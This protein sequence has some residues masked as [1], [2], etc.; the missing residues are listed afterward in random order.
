ML[1]FESLVLTHLWQSSLTIAVVGLAVT[2]FARRRPHLAYALWTLALLKCLTPP[3]VSSPVSP[4]SWS[5][6]AA[7]PSAIGMPAST[8]VNYH[9]APA[10]LLPPRPMDG[11]ATLVTED[12]RPVLT[13]PQPP[14][15]ASSP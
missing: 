12:N 7:A 15:T 11:A 8:P 14:H 9:A 4:F 3:I 10:L 5:T 2:L 6:A 1:P 13:T